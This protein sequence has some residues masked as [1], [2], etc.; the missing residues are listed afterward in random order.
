MARGA[1]LKPSRSP[2]GSCAPNAAAVVGMSLGGATTIRL[3]SQ[4]PELCRAVVIVDV[5]PQVTAPGRELTVE[6]RGSVALV[7]GP[8]TYDSYE[9]MVDATVALSPNRPRS[10]IA[11]G[12]RHN[13]YALPDGR[14][15]WRYDLFGDSER[16]QP[17]DFTSLWDDVARLSMA[18]MFVRGGSSP[19]VLDEDVTEWR[20]RLPATRVEVVAGAGHAVQSDQPLVLARLIE[21]FVFG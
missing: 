16:R 20:R 3:A 17:L 7:S 14:W 9:A 2:C 12:V 5:T 1:T 8:P 19:F 13:A 18:V 15:T 11:R 21:E 4:W 10:A 6:Q